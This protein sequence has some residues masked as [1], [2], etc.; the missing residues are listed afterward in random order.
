MAKQ[1]ARQSKRRG[2]AQA[3]GLVSGRVRS[4]SST[5]G[6]AEMRLLTQWD[7]IVGPT[8]A[9][10][11]RP[12][13]VS[14]SSGGLGATLMVSC[15]GARAPEVEMQLPQLQE[16]V[17]AC[18]GY[19]AIRRIRLTQ[20]APSGFAEPQTAYQPPAPKADPKAISAL[21]LDNV[22]DERLRAALESL[23]ENVLTR[24]AQNKPKR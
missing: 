16:R 22:K 2:F 12:V 17:N 11:V 3:G 13:K 19:N 7:A 6:F 1:P 14:Y 23:G 15:E 8:L 9:A 20:S 10:L 21:C 4:A 18:Y 5:R 24:P